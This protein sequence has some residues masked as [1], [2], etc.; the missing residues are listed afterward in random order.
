MVSGYPPGSER[1]LLGFLHRKSKVDW[2]ELNVQ[3]EN[4]VTYITVDGPASVEALMWKNGFTFKGSTLSIAPADGSVPSTPMR[5]GRSLKTNQQQGKRSNVLADFLQ[6]RWDPQQGFLNLD[7]LPPTSHSIA[8]VISRLLTEASNI[9][10]NS[11]VTVSFARNK[12]WSLQPINKLA[13]LLPSVRNLSVQEN[14]ISEFRHLNSFSNNKLPNLTELVLL[15]NPIQLESSPDLYISEIISR[16]PS[17]SQ[18]DFQPVNQNGGGPLA[19]SLTNSNGSLPLPIKASFFD[20]D[21]SR[22]AAQDLLSKFFPLF[23]SNRSALADL[24]DNQSTFSINVSPT[25]YAKTTWNQGQRVTIGNDNI[26][27]RFAM[28]PPTIHDLSHAEN[29]VTDAWQTPGSSTHPVLLYLTVHGSFREAS[30]EVSFDRVFLIAPSSPG[31]RSQSAGWQYVI[32]SDSMIIRNH[33]YL[34]TV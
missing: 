13:T 8:V 27:K 21:S 30:G 20:Q 23:D 2:E 11:I 10:G 28:F 24:Y 34:P 18:L 4:G 15:G 31:S 14:D 1:D 6:E 16:F 33:S 7:D 17:I 3:N 29:F 26:S 12:L 5:Q 22:Q 32:L 9:Y 25:C 19:P